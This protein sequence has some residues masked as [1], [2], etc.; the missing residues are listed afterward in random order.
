MRNSHQNMPIPALAPARAAALGAPLDAGLLRSLAE[1]LRRLRS[2]KLDSPQVIAAIAVAVALAHAA[3]GETSGVIA[4]IPGDMHWSPQGGFAMPGMEQANL[5]G[6]PKKPGPYTLR[7]K[8]PAGYR[9]APH[10][11]PDAREVTILSGT[12][13]TGYGERWDNASLKE[14][15]A[16]SF[17]TE[18]AN[19]A[20]FIEVREPVLIQVSGVGPSTRK[21]LETA[22]TP[23]STDSPK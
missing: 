2:V 3:I 20:H 15:P 10:T 9:L 7:L 18:P 21:F 5:V 17:Y 11:H 23:S 6:D 13:Y 12:F 22:A 19:M 16:G 8:F 14:L 1:R 4:L